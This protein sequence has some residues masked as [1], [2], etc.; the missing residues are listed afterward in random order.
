MAT[1]MVELFGIGL[2]PGGK[3]YVATPPTRGPLLT[4]SPAS[5]ALGTL[6]AAG[7]M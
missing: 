1:P 5:E 2:G 7:V 4:L 3:G 6:Y